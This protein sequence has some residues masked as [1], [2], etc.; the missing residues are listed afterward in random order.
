[1]N[2]QEAERLARLNAKDREAHVYLVDAEKVYFK[3]Y[4]DAKLIR[5]KFSCVYLGIGLEPS[6][7]AKIN[8]PV[9][10]KSRK[11]YFDIKIKIKSS[12]F[13]KGM[14]CCYCEIELNESNCT[15]E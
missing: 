12:Y 14:I 7:L 11:N 8:Y 2:L 10:G 9:K 3:V 5:C 13:K 4:R 1:M 6:Y 15:R